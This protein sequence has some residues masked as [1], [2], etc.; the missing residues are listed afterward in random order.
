MSAVLCG[1]ATAGDITLAE[2]GIVCDMGESGKYTVDLPRLERNSPVQPGE[3]KVEGN[4]LTAS[5]PAPL[6]GAGLKMTL[7]ENGRVQLV[8][9]GV[10]E[11]VK[12]CILAG[13]QFPLGFAEDGTTFSFDDEAQKPFP[14]EVVKEIIFQ[15]KD[16]AGKFRLIRANG[17][18][19][20]M[21]A[22]AWYAMQDCRPW[23]KDYFTLTNVITLPC[24]RQEGATY[25]ST[26]SYSV[27]ISRVGKASENVPKILKAKFDVKPSGGLTGTKFGLDASR[28]YASDS[29]IV[30]YLWDLDGDGEYESAGTGDSSSYAPEKAGTYRIGLKIVDSNNA[31]AVVSRN[32]I[33]GESVTVGG[34]TLST[35]AIGPDPKLPNDGRGSWTLVANYTFGTAREGTLDDPTITDRRLL[36]QYMHCYNP[37]GSPD[38]SGQYWAKTWIPPEAVEIGDNPY[39]MDVYSPDAPNHE[40]TGNAVRCWVRSLDGEMKQGHFSYGYLRTKFKW[41]NPAIT[42]QDIYAEVK[43]RMAPNPNHP[44]DMRFFWLAFWSNDVPYTGEMDW[45]EGFGY[46]NGPGNNNFKAEGNAVYHS[47]WAKGSG[48]RGYISSKTWTTHT[49]P[50]SDLKKWTI[51]GGLLCSDGFWSTYA[52]CA[53]KPGV[54]FVPNYGTYTKNT[55]KDNWQYYLDGTHGNQKVKNCMPPG[56]SNESNIDAS[57][58]PYAYDWEYLRI[59]MRDKKENEKNP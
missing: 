1:S 22:K 15:H 52:T 9:T 10:P 6:E 16:N 47:D 42:G 5:Y 28:S 49:P 2:T 59:Y 54:Q 3:I 40:I 33:V 18:T 20:S 46:D 55:F 56:I 23:D 45:L 36:V 37:F 41:A 48:A 11:D 27:V 39:K 19:L 38:C 17:D 31:E 14:K 29:A 35:P 44:D 50:G 58:F 43:F 4:V 8:F 30:K 25:T 13:I 51:F 21:V 24:D 12:R 53:A 26:V 7:L 32:V 34:G 57:W